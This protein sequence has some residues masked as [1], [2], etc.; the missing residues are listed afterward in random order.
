MHDVAPN[1][2][3]AYLDEL[4]QRSRAEEIESADRDYR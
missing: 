4:V 3:V 1:Q 2:V